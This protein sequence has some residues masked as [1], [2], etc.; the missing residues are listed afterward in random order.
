MEAS[1]KMADELLQLCNVPITDLK[2]KKYT[3]E[4]LNPNLA[5]LTPSPLIIPLQ[6]SMTVS[7][8][9][10]SSSES[11]HQPFPSDAPTI[12]GKENLWDLI[13]FYW[14]FLTSELCSVS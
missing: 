12:V 8:P 5:K 3:L 4:G 2:K 7:L 9:P 1:K 11:R 6:E 13:Y 10:T 14:I